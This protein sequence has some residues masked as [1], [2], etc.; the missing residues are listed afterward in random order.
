MS[1]RQK[2]FKRNKSYILY[3][4]NHFPCIVLLGARQVGKTT[5]ARSLKKADYFDLESNKEKENQ[6]DSKKEKTAEEKIRMIEL[7]IAETE[8][9][10]EK[11]ETEITKKRS[12][13]GLSTGVN[14]VDSISIQTLKEKMEK[15]LK[16][17]SILEEKTGDGGNKE[18]GTKESGAEKI[19]T[20]EFDGFMATARRLAGHL[21][22]RDSAGPNSLMEDP[23]KVFSAVSSLNSALGSQNP[24]TMAVGRAISKIADIIGELGEKQN[25]TSLKENPESLSKLAGIL[26]NMTRES[27][28]LGSRINKKENVSDML[29]ALS[30][31]EAT[32]NRKTVALGQKIEL[33]RRY[34]GR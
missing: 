25:R 12:S 14:E 8:D 20:V 21:K 19:K 29:P 31:I 2:M 28:M 3:A 9:L 7:E 11:E 1:A 6:V 13:L 33:L 32:T 30:R 15:L 10:L 34:G 26:A 24:D 18:V 5:L 16:E 4:L 23:D 27:Q 22:E 17:K